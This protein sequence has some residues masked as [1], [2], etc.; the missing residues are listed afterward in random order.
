MTP[1]RVR[2]KGSTQVHTVCGE[3]EDDYLLTNYSGMVWYV[4]KDAVEVVE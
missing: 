3:T 1:R 4:R 2:L